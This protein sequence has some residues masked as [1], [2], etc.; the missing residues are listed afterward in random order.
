MVR[1]PTLLAHTRRVIAAY[2]EA[3]AILAR[4]LG[5]CHPIRLA[6]MQLKEERDEVAKRLEE[7][8]SEDQS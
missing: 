6:I 7:K 5:P 3:D 8:E 2:D 1:D 4:H